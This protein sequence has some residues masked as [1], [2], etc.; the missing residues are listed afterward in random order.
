MTFDIGHAEGLVFG[1]ER[2]GTRE[3]ADGNQTQQL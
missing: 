2:D 3:P 1:I